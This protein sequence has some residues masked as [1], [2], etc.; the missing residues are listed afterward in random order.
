[1]TTPT[2]FYDEATHQWIETPP[3]PADAVPAAPAPAPAKSK[4]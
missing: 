3:A 1:M 4:E 2:K